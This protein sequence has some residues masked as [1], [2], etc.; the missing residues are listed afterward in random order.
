MVFLEYFPIWLIIPLYYDCEWIKHHLLHRYM[1]LFNL[2]SVLDIVYFLFFFF[3]HETLWVLYII[4]CISSS[5]FLK[6]VNYLVKRN[7]YSWNLIY[8]FKLLLEKIN[9]VYILTGNS[10]LHFLSW[11]ASHCVSSLKYF[12][13]F[14]LWLLEWYSSK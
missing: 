10:L 14:L 9:S 13:P 6:I 12:L 3:Y 11:S 4:L 8:I 1:M 2:S 5:R 7:E